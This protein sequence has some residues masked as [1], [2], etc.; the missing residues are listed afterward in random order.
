MLAHRRVNKSVKQKK[1]RMKTKGRVTG[2][3]FLLPWKP[4]SKR[5]RKDLLLL[6][7]RLPDHDQT[8]QK[9]KLQKSYTQIQIFNTPDIRNLKKHCFLMCSEVSKKCDVLRFVGVKKPATNKNWPQKPGANLLEHTASS[10]ARGLKA[11]QLRCP[12]SPRLTSIHYGERV[13]EYFLRAL[14]VIDGSKAMNCG[15]WS[16][17]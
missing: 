13:R 1:E 12:L 9:K 7:F 16:Q 15:R 17:F 6:Q 14:G 3:V 5:L 4:W 11:S 10:L 8:K 2:F